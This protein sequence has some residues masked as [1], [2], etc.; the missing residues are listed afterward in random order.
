M[1]IGDRLKALFSGMNVDYSKNIQSLKSNALEGLES[2]F[3][4]KGFEV[5]NRWIRF[6]SFLQKFERND[7]NSQNCYFGSFVSKLPKAFLFLLKALF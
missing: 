2:F 5:L 6:K 1:E 3:F 4:I 7:T